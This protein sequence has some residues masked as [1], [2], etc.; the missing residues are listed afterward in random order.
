[1]WDFLARP[2]I[3][4]VIAAPDGCARGARVPQVVIDFTPLPSEHVQV[5]LPGRCKFGL[6]SVLQLCDADHANIIGT[7]ARE[8]QHDGMMP[9]GIG[10]IGPDQ[11]PVR[12]LATDQP[13]LSGPSGNRISPLGSSA[14][15]T[16]CGSQ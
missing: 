12:D 6:R 16:T 11:Q 9:P 8:R 15:W 1:M 10:V 7:V 5:A 14:G 3:A 4:Q 13:R 2:I